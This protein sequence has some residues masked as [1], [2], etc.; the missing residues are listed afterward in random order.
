MPRIAR[1]TLENGCY[2]I[3]TRGNQKQTV[4]LESKDFEKYLHLLT[5]YKIKFK[6][7][8]YSF[9]L[10]SN[11][12][13]LLL[14]VAKPPTLNKIMSGLN[15]SYT[16]YFNFKYQKVGHLW[17]DRFKSKLIDKDSYLLGCI[18]YIEFNPIR[19]SLVKRIE[20]YKWTSFNLRNIKNDLIDS[21]F[22]L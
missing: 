22:C 14:E 17:Q 19:S 4:F 18:N 9:C 16:R 12:V 11:H 5:K 15:L 2:H 20:D 13:H 1:I 7:K 10:M 21:L 3:I 8:L 6:F